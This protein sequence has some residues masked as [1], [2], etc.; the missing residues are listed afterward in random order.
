ML[1][2]V[3]AARTPHRGHAACVTAR[4]V[5]CGALEPPSGTLDLVNFSLFGA[6]AI[7]IAFLSVALPEDHVREPHHEVG[8]RLSGVCHCFSP[9]PFYY[10]TA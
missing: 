8:E 2:F 6:A 10:I 4:G 9:I 5:C 3:S 1:T 7:V